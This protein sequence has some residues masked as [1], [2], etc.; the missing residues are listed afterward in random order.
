VGL[1]GPS[2]ATILARDCS[3]DARVTGPSALRGR[4]RDA[5]TGGPA[6]DA[7]VL[8]TWNR[9][10]RST[11]AGVVPVVEQSLATRTDS[12]GRYELCGIPEGVKLAARARTDDRRSARVDLLVPTQEISILDLTVGRPVTVASVEPRAVAP[13]AADAT[14]AGPKN[15]MA[16]ALERR[17]HRG[18]GSFLT[19]TQIERL[20]ATRLTDLLRTMPGI[21]VTTDGSGTPM[22]ELRGSTRIRLQPAR[23]ASSDSG[24]PPPN[25]AGGQMTIEKCAAGFHVDGLAMG[26]AGIDSDVRPDDIEAIE[27]YASGQVPLEF[28]ARNAECGV[29]LIWTRAYV[30]T[31][32]GQSQDRDGGR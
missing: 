7:E 18:G 8:V 1:A 27:V 3:A 23:A 28:S 19:R 14:P 24:P 16:E 32:E 12:A 25:P 30:G 6:I 20:S 2:A 15:R 31:R 29:V 22:V 10:A 21:T 5:A 17:R 26:A 11:A 13:V 4:V 9:M